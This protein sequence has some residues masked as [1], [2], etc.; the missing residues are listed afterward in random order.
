MRRFGA[1]LRTALIVGIV[2]QAQ[3]LAAPGQTMPALPPA[4]SDR[5]DRIAL[6]ELH[7]G[8]TPGIAIGVV[9]DGQL[10]YARGF[11]F[12]TLSPHAPMT[13]DTEFYAGGLTM[14]FTAAAILL[15]EQDGKLKLDD[16]VSKYVPELKVAANVT[17]EQ[18]LT[19]TSGLPNYTGAPGVPRDVTRSVKLDDL[20]TAVDKLKPW[21]PPGTAYSNNPL[22]YLLAGLIVQRTSGVT[23][24]DFLEQRIFIPLVMS[25]TF[26]AGDNGISTSHATGYTRG[27]GGFA[28]APSWDPAWLGGAAGLVTTIDDL[29]KWDIEM[30]VLLRVDA[31]R[32][33]YTAAGTV[34]P[35]HY[36]MGWVIDSRGGKEFVWSNGQISGYRAVNAQLPSQH[37]GVIVFSNSDALHGGVTVP[38]AVGTRVLDVLTPPSYTRLDNSVV[39]RA[40]EWL[41]RLASKQLDRSELTPT[42]SA[43]LTD[44]L[45]ARENFAALGRLQVMVPISS[46]TESNGDTLY[47]FLVRYPHAQYRYNFEVAPDG[48]IDGLGL[49]T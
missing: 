38:E 34:G 2:A 23:L 1:V 48:K 42:F 16:P 17:I 10:V 47:E 39:T 22:N 29:A 25:H 43:Y 3:P 46:S 13:A 37:V 28:V 12:A 32:T 41:S 14:Q 26:L 40:K 15:L 8:R 19:Q 44:D 24:S 21:A 45:V 20:F 6:D 35:T 49:V 4:V 5:I 33:M 18:L 30:P 31:V 9:E 7:A 36:G 27:A 11:G